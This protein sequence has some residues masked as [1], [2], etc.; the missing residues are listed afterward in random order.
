MVGRNDRDRLNTV[1]AGRLAIGHSRKIRVA[2][3]RIEAEHRRRNALPAWSE[4]K[5]PCDEFIAV[6]KAGCDAMHRA[7]E[8]TLAAAHHPEPDAA[9]P[10]GVEAGERPAGLPPHHAAAPRSAMILSATRQALAMMVSV[11]LAPVP[12]GKGEP[13]T[14]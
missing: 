10:S 2:S 14:A 8:R 13:S 12:V 7:D 6:V 1:R 9:L 4:D 11:G 3:R 5:C